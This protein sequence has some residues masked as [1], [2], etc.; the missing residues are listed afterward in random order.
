MK[1]D[2]PIDSM[3]MKNPAV[4]PHTIIK[5]ETASSFRTLHIT[6]HGVTS[7]N[8]VFF[9]FTIVSNSNFT[10]RKADQK[11]RGR[12]TVLATRELRHFVTQV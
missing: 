7:R 6:V 2:S 11:C 1:P 3:T 10:Y 8:T 12:N 5:R 4:F 9:I